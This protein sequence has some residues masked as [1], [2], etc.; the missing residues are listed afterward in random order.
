MTVE[1]NG[2]GMRCFIV[3]PIGGDNTEIRRAAEGV[4]DAVVLP[5]L[6]NNFGFRDTNIT[7]AHRMPQ[8][9][10]INRQVIQRILEDDLVITNLTGL[11][12]NVMYELAIRHASR[13]PVI[14]ICENGTKL[15]FDIAI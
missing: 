9:G 13:K 11:N 3:T 6:I 15:P 1:E 7:V 2:N 5:L 4:I 14:I 12:P 8:A 10:S